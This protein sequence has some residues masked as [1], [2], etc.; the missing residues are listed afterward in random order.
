[1]RTITWQFTILPG[2]EAEAEAA[3]KKVVEGVDKNEPGALAYHWYRNL[4]DQMQILVFEV[5]KDD[6][7]IETHRGMPYM[8]EF[9]SVFATVFDQAGV[10]RNR[11][12]RIAAI[13]R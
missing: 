3:I 8:S 11:Y 9:Q 1:M 10:K 7:A 4:K 13:T 5:W 6:E 12:E 2:K